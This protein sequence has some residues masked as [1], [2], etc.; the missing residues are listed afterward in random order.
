LTRASSKPTTT[1][2]ETAVANNEAEVGNQVSESSSLDLTVE[3]AAAVKAVRLAS[4][5]CDN[6]QWQLRNDE[7]VEKEDGSP[8]TVADYGAQV[9]VSWSLQRSLPG[10]TFNM[11]GEED[12]AD[13]RTEEEG[14]CCGVSRTW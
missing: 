3:L 5:L 9:L 7:K 11:V 2:I 6:V 13:L 10:Q 12:S 14:R 1:A 8:V 4:H